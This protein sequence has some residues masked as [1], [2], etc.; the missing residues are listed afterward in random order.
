MSDL[1]YLLDSAWLAE[2]EK[3]W[4]KYSKRWLY[5][6]S[7]KEKNIAR[8]YFFDGDVRHL[9]T[10]EYP[11]T[12]SDVISTTPMNDAD[13]V[14]KAISE[15]WF[16]VLEKPESRDYFENI[17]EINKRFLYHFNAIYSRKGDCI[18]PN[19]CVGLF[20]WLYGRTYEKSRVVDLQHNG[21]SISIP[22]KVEKDQL[23]FDLLSG[24]IKYLWRQDEGENICIFKSFIP[25]F[26]TI[27]P[28]MSPICFDT[29]LP[30]EKKF[31]INGEKYDRKYFIWNRWLLTNLNGYISEYEEEEEVEELVCSDK[32]A[33]AQLKEGLESIDMPCEFYRLKEFVLRYKGDSLYA[34]E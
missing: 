11:S 7:E 31:E 13:K 20:A 10:D 3:K 34:S 16:W 25:Y 8:S 9:M 21:K 18:S 24:I 26:L 17:P 14:I 5:D 4:E 27:Y 6:F 1:S 15:F 32:E 30:R 19:V 28:H 33:L 12:L 29:K 2:R 23:S 22:L